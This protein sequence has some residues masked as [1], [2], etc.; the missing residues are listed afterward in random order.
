MKSISVYQYLHPAEELLFGW[1]ISIL[2]VIVDDLAGCTVLNHV[3]EGIADVSTFGLGH[4]F[5][6][7]LLLFVVGEHLAFTKFILLVLTHLLVSPLLLLQKS[8]LF[9]L[10]I[11]LSRF[12]VFP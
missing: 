3:V 7:E 11:V 1:V 9:N 5:V 10:H 8:L 4:S 6:I 2:F 12:Y